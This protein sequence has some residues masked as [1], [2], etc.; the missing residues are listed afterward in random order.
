MRIL[1]STYSPR[2]RAQVFCSFA[3]VDLLSLILLLLFPFFAVAVGEEESAIAPSAR[4]S[5]LEGS[6]DLAPEKEEEGVFR[7]SSRI[8]CLQMAR[9]WRCKMVEEED[10]L[11]VGLEV[12]QNVSWSV[13][14]LGHCKLALV[15]AVG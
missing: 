1:L 14:G 6:L 12:A 15:L 4:A 10:V 9:L 7:P 13:Q 5:L 2:L 11:V 8:S 3:H